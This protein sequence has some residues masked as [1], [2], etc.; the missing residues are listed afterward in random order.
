M[1]GDRAV[2]GPHGKCAPK[3]RS[4]PVR[5]LLAG[6]RGGRIVH[7]L[8]TTVMVPNGPQ[9]TARSPPPKLIGR[10]GDGAT[11]NGDMV[12][13]EPGQLRCCPRPVR[14]EEHTSELQSQS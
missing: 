9:L 12:E 6:C 11:R 13:R 10:Y 8:A 14:S 2:R 4:S 5:T 7:H 3:A 1:R